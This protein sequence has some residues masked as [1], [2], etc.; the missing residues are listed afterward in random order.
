MVVKQHNSQKIVPKA[1]SYIYNLQTNHT[2]KKQKS[3][4]Y[5][6]MR[7]KQNEYSGLSRE[8]EDGLPSESEKIKQIASTNRETECDPDK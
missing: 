2:N 4:S 8:L 6:E 5:K 1:K 3:K 7:E